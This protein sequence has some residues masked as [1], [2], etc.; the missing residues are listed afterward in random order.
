MLKCILV[1]M[2]FVSTAFGGL[3]AWSATIQGPPDAQGSQFNTREE[4]IGGLRLGLAEK[5]V[6]KIIP[7]RPKKGKEVFEAATGEY[8]QTWKYAECGIVLKMSSDHRG[9]AKE[10]A[11]ILITSR[12]KLVTGKGIHI[13]ST[14]K[15]VIRA[16][17]RYGDQD[18]NTVKGQRFVAGS[19][20]DGLVFD[21]KGGR[22]ISIFLGAGAE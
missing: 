21:F 9:G 4:R 12:C 1:F 19:I 18:G 8:V 7:G 11:S 17:G 6:N 22:V 16:Y 20:Y 3:P 15:E 13:G 5:D 10:I 2:M 14:E